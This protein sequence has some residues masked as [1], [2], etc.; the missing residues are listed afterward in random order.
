MCTK[1]SI[2]NHFILQN[3]PPLTYIKKIPLNLFPSTVTYYFT[4]PSL[5][6]LATFDVLPFLVRSYY[7]SYS[8]LTRLFFDL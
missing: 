8:F 7:V 5:L 2:F 6:A 1:H 3:I 4:F